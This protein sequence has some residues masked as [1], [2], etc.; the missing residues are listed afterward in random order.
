VIAVAVLAGVVGAMIGSFLNVVIA[1]LP[2]GESLSH[3]PSHCP[4]CGTPI[5]PYDNVPVV[6]WLFLRAKCR[7]C[8]ER[9]SAR[10]PG[11][12]LLTAL[13][14]ASVVVVKG[15]DSE[16]AL[17]LPFAAVLIAIA[18]IDFDHKI[19]PNKIVVP[20]AVYGVAVAAIVH[21]GELPEDLIAGAAAFGFLLIAALAYPAGMGMGDVKLAGVMGVFLGAAVAPALFIAFLAGALVGIAMIAKQGAAARK[22]G[23]PFGPFLAVGGI[24]ALLAGDQL[25]QAY[26]DRFL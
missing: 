4:K 26:S 1:R 13:V 5:K 18:F 6:S 20:A 2:A 14:F 25:V 22:K 9:I 7:S 12:E 8:G 21:P 3:P 23:V 11:V 10:Y 15:A 16:L 17:E 19:I 24:V